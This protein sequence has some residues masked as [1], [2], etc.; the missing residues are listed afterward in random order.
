[1]K[2]TVA[3]GPIPPRTPIKAIFGLLFLQ[4]SVPVAGMTVAARS[5]EDNLRS[6]AQILAFARKNHDT[7]R[8]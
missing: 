8:T 4:R 6:I 7:T 1:M 2:S 3:S 5:H